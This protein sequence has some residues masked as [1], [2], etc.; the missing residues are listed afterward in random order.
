MDEHFL[1]LLADEKNAPT[2]SQRICVEEGQYC[3]SVGKEELWFIVP[4]TKIVYDRNEYNFG[5]YTIVLHYF[6]VF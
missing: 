5:S 3:K 2:L 1:D 6:V 4:F